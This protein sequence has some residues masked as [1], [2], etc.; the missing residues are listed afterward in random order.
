MRVH[1]AAWVLPMAGPLLRDAW[2]SVDR[3]QIVAVG[4]GESP[5]RIETSRAPET[6]ERTAILPGLVNAHTH[7]ELSWMR[8]RVPQGAAMPEWAARLIALR[9]TSTPDEASRMH[10]VTGAIQEARASGT[11]LVG[12]IGNGGDAVAP[13]LASA[14]SARVFRELIGFRV[15]DDAA[16]VVAAA[17]AVLPAGADSGRVRPSLAAHAPYS[18]SAQLLQAISA[19]APDDPFCIHLAESAEEMEFL[20]EG[21]GAWR[22]VLESVGAW[23]PAWRPPGVGPVEYL[24]RLGLLTSRLV[25]VHGVQLD[26]AALARLEAAGATVVMCPRSNRWTGAGDPPIARFFASGVRVAI[27][28]DSLASVA[29]LSVFDELAAARRLAPEVPAAALLRSATIDGAAALGFGDVLG[30]IAPGKRA[31]LI[32]VRVPAGVTDVEEYLLSGIQP[33]AVSWLA[34]N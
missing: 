25:A 22:G 32:A 20:R 31:E 26:A 5:E 30:T 13:L 9:A 10:A 7:L 14:M 16:G 21:S 17:R 11:A 6:G 12:D 28:T 19:G 33:D 24:D 4:T 1:R 15:T 3:G 27:G 34:S 2:V 18:V 29:T 23:L 8:G